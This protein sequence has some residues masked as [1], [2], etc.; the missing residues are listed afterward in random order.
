MK[1]TAHDKALV[2]PKAKIGEGT[3]IWAFVNVQEGAVIGKHCKIAD[4]C[5]IEKGGVVGNYVTLKNHVFVFEGVTIEDDVFIGA[6]VAF[7]NDRYPRGHRLDQWTLEKVTVKKGA[8][9]GANATILCGVTIGE[10]ALIGA[11]SV[12]TRDVPRHGLILGNPGVLK[13]YACQCGHTLDKKLKCVCGR[14]YRLKK[15]GLFLKE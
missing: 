9:I 6:N 8:T 4:G 13:G 5:F 10:Y 2:H 11:G 14:Q 1:Y 12:V 15:Q 3:R 7:I